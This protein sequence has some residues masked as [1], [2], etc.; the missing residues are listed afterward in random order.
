M[1]YGYLKGENNLADILSKHWAYQAVWK[2]LRPVLFWKGD[3]MDIVRNEEKKVSNG[4]VRND[5][6]S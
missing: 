6:E 5:I 2:L 1:T 3:T 4:N